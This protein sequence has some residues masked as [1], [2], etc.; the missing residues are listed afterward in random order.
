MDSTE[1]Q[2]SSAHKRTRK[3]NWS[4]D[5]TKFLV[6]LYR[7]NVKYLKCEFASPGTSH[8]GRLDAWDRIAA[9][10]HTAYPSADRTVKECQKR[11]QTIQSLGQKLLV[12]T[13]QLI[14]QVRILLFLEK[15]V[16]LYTHPD[17][18]TLRNVFSHPTLYER[19]LR[20][21]ESHYRYW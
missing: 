14:K 10:L 13:R 17:R 11:W 5:E 16:I 7:E 2:A 19:I 18:C 3:M 9:S 12:T 8:R 15:V 4:S 6:E 1:R 21:S 20:I